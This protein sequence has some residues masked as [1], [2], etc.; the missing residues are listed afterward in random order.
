V[1]PLYHKKSNV[2]AGYLIFL[3]ISGLGFWKKIKIFFFPEESKN[4]IWLHLVLG[5][6]KNGQFLKN[7]SQRMGSCI[8][9]YI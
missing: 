9:G 4:I 8:K 1:A 2:G 3:I 6:S 5:F 7:S